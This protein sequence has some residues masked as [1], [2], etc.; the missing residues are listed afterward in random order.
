MKAFSL[1][2]NETIVFI[3]TMWISFLSEIFKKFKCDNNLQI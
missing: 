2:K 1:H 3:D